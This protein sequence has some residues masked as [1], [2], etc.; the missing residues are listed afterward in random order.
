MSDY[1][2]NSEEFG[3]LADNALETMGGLFQVDWVQLTRDDIIAI[4][5]KAYK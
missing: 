2:I 1:G 4:L 3:R 5:Q